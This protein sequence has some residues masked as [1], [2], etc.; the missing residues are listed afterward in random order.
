MA[1]RSDVVEGFYTRLESAATGVT[2]IDGDD[3]R[4]AEP[5]T[6]YTPPVVVYSYDFDRVDVNEIGTVNSTETDNSGNVDTLLFD[7]NESALFTVSY[8]TG[9]YGDRNTVADS[10]QDEFQKYEETP[11]W[12][13]PLSDFH[14]DVWDIRV[15]SHDATSA[16]ETEDTYRDGMLQV[17]LKFRNQTS[18]SVDP[19]TSVDHD[20]DFEAGD[21]AADWEG[22]TS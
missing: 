3:V 7:R 14:D 17:E 6:T 22:N 11:E 5:N 12:Q 10:L 1:N 16:P 15:L 4:L 8:R 21:S 2:D 20:V 19:I 18:I 9:G 13:N